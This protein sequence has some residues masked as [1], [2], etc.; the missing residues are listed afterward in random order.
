[1]ISQSEMEDV[2]RILDRII[3]K[4][5]IFTPRTLRMGSVGISAITSM[6][7]IVG[8]LSPA[9]SCAGGWPRPRLKGRAYAKIEELCERRMGR[10]RH[11]EWGDVWCP[12]TGEKVAEVPYSTTADVDAAVKAAREAFWDWRCTPPMTRARYF[13]KLKELLEKSFEDIARTLV[14]EEGKTLDESRGEVRRMIENVEHATGV[15]T[16]MTGYNLEDISQGIDST[17]ERQPIGV[18]GCIAPFNFPAMVPWWFLPYAVVSGN[19][20]IVKPSEQVP[21]TQARI[22]EAVDECNFPEGVV[23]M[24]H[25]SR[26][27]VNAMLYHPDI[28]GMSFVGQ[29]FHRQV[30]LQSLRRDGKARPVPGRRQELPPRDA[31]CGPR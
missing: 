21:M 14:I 28:N 13:F 4:I 8:R 11:T 10:F 9:R 12:A 26:D 1:M 5:L 20:Y 7:V 25:G 16:M 27:V 29:S 23:N 30:R 6:F 24:V 31:R 15:T 17:A 3:G 18:F 19:T 22:F 2:V